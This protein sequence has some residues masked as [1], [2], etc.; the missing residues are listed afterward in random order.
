LHQQ[1]AVG[2]VI[3]VKMPKGTFYFDA[4][5]KCPAVLI[6]AGVGITPMVSMLRHALQEGIRTRS[7]RDITVI[8]SARNAAQ[9]AFFLNSRKL[10]II[11][12]IGFVF[13]G[14]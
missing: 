10:L 14:H 5:Q 9:R 12:L 13:F 1:I 2:D 7:M 11:L 3:E 8:C 4:A 6:A